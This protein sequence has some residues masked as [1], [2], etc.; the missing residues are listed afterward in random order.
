MIV[1]RP[2]GSRVPA[3]GLLLA[4]FLAASL[5]LTVKPAHADTTFTVD[6]TG[7]FEDATPVDN[8]R[9]INPNPSFEFCTLRAAIQ[10]ANVTPGADTIEFN[11]T[12]DESPVKT[13]TPRSKLP[14]ITEAVTIDGY[15][16]PGAA[17]NTDTRPGKTNARPLVQIVGSSVT[18]D[19]FPKDG[20]EVGASNVVVRGL[21]VNRGLQNHFLCASEERPRSGVGADD[22]R[23]SH[24]PGA[25]PRG[26]RLGATPGPRY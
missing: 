5:M 12:D 21:V 19:V 7:D 20:L 24:P 8:S 14:E 3:L 11:I 13:I 22:A 26:E 4:V 10:Q 6:F 2:A 18:G 15:T 9:D 16:Q 17:E 1:Q 25:G 23:H